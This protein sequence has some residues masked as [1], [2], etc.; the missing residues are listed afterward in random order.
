MIFFARFRVG[1]GVDTVRA[2][3][4]V[5]VLDSRNMDKARSNWIRLGKTKTNAE[6]AGCKLLNVK[7]NNGNM[8]LTDV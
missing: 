8:Y 4:T 5:K 7:M 1:V 2:R 6:I 3:V